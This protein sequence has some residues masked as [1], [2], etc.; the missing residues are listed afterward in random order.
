MRN[1][2]VRQAHAGAIVRAAMA[3]HAPAI[4]LP[5]P[6]AERQSEIVATMRLAAPIVL[7]NL[8]QMAINTTDVLLM[9]WLG[10]DAL[11]AGAL[12]TN[13]FFVVMISSL[14]IV[15]AVSPLAAQAV[16]AGR[17]NA[18]NRALHAGLWSTAVL[19]LPGGLAVWYAPAALLWLGEPPAT[20]AMTAEYLTTLVWSLPAFLGFAALRGY[21]AAHERPTAATVITLAG[22]AANAVIVYA[23]MFGRFGLPALGL[24]GAGIGTTIVNVLM[25]AAL[26]GF[27][28]A[29]PHFR[30][31][32]AFRGLMRPPVRQLR[33]LLRIGVPIGATMLLEV[34]LFA[35]AAL[36]MGLIG[37]HELAAYQIALQMAAIA[38][39]IPMGIGQAATVRVGLA[40]GAGDHA[41]A[42]HAG[43]TAL[44]LGLVIIVGAAVVM[45]TLPHELVGLFVDRAA[46]ETEAVASLAATFL[47][48]AAIFQLVDATQGIAVGMLRGL[49]DTRVPMMIC[50]LGYWAIG[51][52]LGL[53]LAFK[54]GFGGIGIW[55]G[56]AVGLAIVAVL[57][58]WRWQ[59]LTSR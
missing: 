21:I 39:M 13:V 26:V 11:A 2:G 57:L 27:V 9:G 24:L 12:G 31:V 16:G 14:G 45:W 5:E 47:A 25:L 18:G 34:G 52:P 1:W 38:F 53:V 29:S 17:I 20:V 36:A 46:P 10:P 37:T 32:G 49:K 56:L 23:L 33:E 54:L 6:R 40:A 48:V 15:V 55:I 42:A 30:R 7:A 28:M 43:W 19:A 22:I 59:R 51:A 8:G 35:A 44:G 41:G 58:V 3:E 4:P 50:A